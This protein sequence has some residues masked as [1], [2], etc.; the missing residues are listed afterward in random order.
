MTLASLGYK[1]KPMSKET[2]VIAL[3]VWVMVMPYLGIPRAWLTAFM[4]LTAIGFV[5]LGFLL[6]AEALSRTARRTG[7]HHPF[8]E[9]VPQETH[10]IDHHEN[11]EQRKERLSSLN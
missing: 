4:I 2:T 8:V 11:H 10:A 6:R 1:I 7:S 3:G 5:V 9:H